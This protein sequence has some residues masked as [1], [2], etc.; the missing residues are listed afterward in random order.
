LTDFLIQATTV[1]AGAWRLVVRISPRQY[2][3]VIFIVSLIALNIYMFYRLTLLVG[4]RRP[5]TPYP[6]LYR[7]EE[8]L[9]FPPNASHHEYR[10]FASIGKPFVIFIGT[11][12]TSVRI[13]GYNLSFVRYLANQVDAYLYFRAENLGLDPV[14][15]FHKNDNWVLIASDYRHH[16]TTETAPVLTLQPLA[17]GFSSIKFTY[18][19]TLEP[20][21]IAWSR[22]TGAG[23]TR[24]VVIWSIA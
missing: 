18:N 2:A 1:Y 21:G 6:V 24:I 17:V 16:Y 23:W 15:I 10:L 8:V 7:P 22:W 13:T 9:R 19:S 20:R 5:L 4:Q 12:V 14:T 11:T 3:G